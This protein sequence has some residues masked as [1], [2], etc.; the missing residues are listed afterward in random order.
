M[1]A[2]SRIRSVSEDFTLVLKTAHNL[3]SHG[4]DGPRSIPTAPD[5]VDVLAAPVVVL[6]ISGIWNR[7]RVS[8]AAVLNSALAGQVL[9]FLQAASVPAASS[10][11]PSLTACY[12]R[13]QISS[14]SML[15]PSFIRTTTA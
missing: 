7:I 14:G 3:L 6:T 5:G 2:S 4:A 1:P 12:D 8:D 15:C 11:L 13:I 10:E 9:S